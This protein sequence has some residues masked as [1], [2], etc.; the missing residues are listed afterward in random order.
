MGPLLTTGSNHTLYNWY[1][2][3]NSSKRH[4]PKEGLHAKPLSHFSGVNSMYQDF[5]SQTC[6]FQIPW[7]SLH[8]P[9]MFHVMLSWCGATPYA[10]RQGVPLRN[11]LPPQWSGWGLRCHARRPHHRPSWRVDQIGKAIQKKNTTKSYLTSQKITGWVNFCFCLL[12]F[13]KSTFDKLSFFSCQVTVLALHKAE[14]FLG[15]AR[16]CLQVSKNDMLGWNPQIGCDTTELTSC[17]EKVDGA[18][19][20]WFM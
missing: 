4:R 18:Q 8:Q 2:K 9:A 19:R 14:S 11:H 3:K 13:P 6:M 5:E 1:W 17:T 12:P 7:I 15:M 16:T 20:Y 10:W